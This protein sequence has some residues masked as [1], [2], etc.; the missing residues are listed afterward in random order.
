[1]ADDRVVREKLGEAEVT[2]MKVLEPE[3]AEHG[4][5]TQEAFNLIGEALA[6][7]S[8]VPVREVSRSR[9]VATALLLRLGN[10]LRCAALLALRGYPTQAASLVASM[11][12]G[13]YSLA[14]IG[15]EESLAQ[16]WIDHDDPTRPFR[17]VRTLTEEVFK[18]QAVPDVANEVDRHY[19]TYRQLCMA[20]HLNP[21]YE[22][23]HAFEL[24]PNLLVAMMGPRT[25]AAAVRGARFALEHAAWLSFVAIS[26]FVDDHLAAADRAK[27]AT[28]LEGLYRRTLKLTEESAERYETK[29]PFPGKW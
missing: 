15:A 2:A 8:G 17:P 16:E 9:Q 10:D 4:A 18:K 1:M 21:L 20:K 29:D 6:P 14:F 24:K 23:Q 5:L 13:A 26:S 27:L 28:R 25:S 11:Y 19:R 7:L 12:E 22:M 3:L